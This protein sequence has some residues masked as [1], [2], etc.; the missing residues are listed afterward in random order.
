MTKGLPRSLKRASG[1]VA[2]IKKDTIL[3]GSAVSVTAAGAAVGFGA[4]VIGDFP[5]GNILVLGS[6]ANFAFAGP[7][8]GNLVDTWNGDF[9]LGTT[10]T[11]DVTLSG[12]EVNLLAS[13]A[14]GP[15]TAEVFAKA[16]YAGV[17]TPALYDNTDG[18]LEINLNLLVDAAD[19]TDGA[20]VAITVTGEYYITYIV[21]GDD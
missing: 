2:P 19:I 20:T 6:V 15:A 11:A 14:I 16:R 8:S 21:L 9:S 5:Q 13:S 17:V 18:S 10:P 1:L 12:T 3:V 7:T 4:A